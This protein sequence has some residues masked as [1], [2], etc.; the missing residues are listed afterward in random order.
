MSSCG[1]HLVLN[2]C[3]VLGLGFNAMAQQRP[4]EPAPDLP[5]DA[6]RNN[7]DGEWVAQRSVTVPAAFGMVQLKP[8]QVVDEDLQERLDVQCQ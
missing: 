4:Q 2:A 8:G 1:K 7:E 3:L 5:C 6:F